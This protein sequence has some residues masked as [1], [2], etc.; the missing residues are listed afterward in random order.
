I[1]VGRLRAGAGAATDTGDVLAATGRIRVHG[2][3]ARPGP[4]LHRRYRLVLLRLV[5]LRLVVLRLVL[6]HARPGGPRLARAR[7]PVVAR[8]HGRPSRLGVLDPRASPLVEP[9]GRR[10][11]VG[12]AWSARRAGTRGPRAARSRPGRGPPAAR[13]CLLRGLLAQVEAAGMYE[14]ARW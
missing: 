3:R 5:L 6:L 8:S 12:V 10:L 2:L 13:R 1:V 7:G 9:A 4:F 11:P 14:A